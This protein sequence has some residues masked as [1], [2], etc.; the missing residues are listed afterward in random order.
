[1]YVAPLI[2]KLSADGFQEMVHDATANKVFHQGRRHGVKLTSS[3]VVRIVALVVDS[4]ASQLNPGAT[5][6]QEADV[7][8][9]VVGEQLPGAASLLRCHLTSR[10]S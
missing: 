8:S 3:E 1:M 6:L 5:V 2:M 4:Q 9:M 7:V 10:D